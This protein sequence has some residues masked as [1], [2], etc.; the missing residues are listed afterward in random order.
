LTKLAKTARGPL[1]ALLLRYLGGLRFPYL[2]A[3]TALVFLVDFVVPDLIPFVDEVL[4]GLATLILAA[5][6]KREPAP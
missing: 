4:L 2:L 1:V 5:W 3:V 6:R